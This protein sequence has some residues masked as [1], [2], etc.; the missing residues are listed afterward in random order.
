M[1]KPTCVAVC[2]LMTEAHKQDNL[3]KAAMMIDSAA[4][5][6]VDL[7]ILPEVFNAPYQAELFADYA[8]PFPGSTSMLLS[9]KARQHRVP[10]IGGSIIEQDERGKLFNTT[11]IF[12]HCGELCGKHRK[13]HLFDIDIPGGITFRESDT[14]HS[15]DQL[16][17]VALGQLTVGIM[18][19]Y[20]IRFPE[21]ARL[22]ALAGAQLLVIPAAF[23]LIT[24]PLHWELL[25]RSRAADNQVFVAAAAPARN[26][27]ADYQS[28]GHSM[29]IDPW[30]RIIAQAGDEETILYCGLDLDLLPQVRSQL[31]LLQ[32]RRSDLYRINWIGPGRRE[33]M[34]GDKEK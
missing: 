31:P 3:D 23:N 19:C 30:G 33:T 21:M 4:G 18:I 25:M 5:Q 34:N 27:E 10:I 1:K 16:T 9:S 12:D 2:Q 32:H 26:P 14:L 15:G 22:A 11:Y 8:E 24:G 29:V 6:K 7:I 17:L 20:D 28:W 13:V